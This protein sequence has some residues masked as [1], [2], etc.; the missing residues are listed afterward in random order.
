MDMKQLENVRELIELVIHA[1]TKADA[2]PYIKRLDFAVSN[3]KPKLDPYF[4]G[5]LSEA[6]T[7]AKE[8]SGQVRNKEHWISCMED[9]WYVFESHIRPKSDDAENR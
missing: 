8:A 9:S 5:K 7:Y 1:S 6:A 3:F 2:K 4:A